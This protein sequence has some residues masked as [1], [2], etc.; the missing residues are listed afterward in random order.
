[1]QKNDSITREWCISNETRYGTFL[2]SSSLYWLSKYVSVNGQSVVRTCQYGS[3]KYHKFQD[4]ESEVEEQVNK[5]LAKHSSQ[6]LCAVLTKDKDALGG[7]RPRAVVSTE[8]HKNQRDDKRKSE[9][10]SRQKKL[11]HADGGFPCCMRQR[12]RRQWNKNERKTKIRKDEEEDSSISS[13]R[14]GRSKTKTAIGCKDLCRCKTTKEIKESERTKDKDII[15]IVLQKNMRSMH[16]SERIED[17]I[18]DLWRLQM[19]CSVIERDLE[20]CQIR[21]LGDTSQ[22]HI[23]GCRKIRPQTRSW[24]SAE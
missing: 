8:K 9:G 10:G 11:T 23:R 3:L 24:N 16:S 12:K 15:F 2:N 6:R 7:G 5:W 19:G 18:F 13:K 22:T 21:I 1:M 14:D 17:M 4:I 20:T